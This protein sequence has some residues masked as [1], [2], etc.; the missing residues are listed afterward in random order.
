MSEEPANPDQQSPQPDI[1][2]SIPGVEPASTEQA[3]QQPQDLVDSV[4]GINP[5]ETASATPTQP[6]DGSEYSGGYAGQRLS[7]DGTSPNVPVINDPAKSDMLGAAARQVQ[8][9]DET[10]KE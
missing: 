9:Q 2:D 10:P 4:P 5:A 7:S 3:P 8:G 6:A 1:I